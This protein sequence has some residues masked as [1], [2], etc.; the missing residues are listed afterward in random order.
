MSVRAGKASRPLHALYMYC[1]GLHPTIQKSR[2]RLEK[3]KPFATRPPETIDQSLVLQ[4][5][6]S[7]S[8][9][10][11]MGLID[12]ALIDDDHIAQNAFHGAAD[13]TAE[14]PRQSLIRILGFNQD[15]N[16]QEPI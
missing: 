14:R 15:G 2:A 3:Q 1:R 5:D 13:Q 12:R 6:A 7:G 11:T 10:N 9:G 8:I 4:K 16:H